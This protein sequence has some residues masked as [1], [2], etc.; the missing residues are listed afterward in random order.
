MPRIDQNAIK[1]VG[2]A[3]ASALLAS[4]SAA[5]SK[6]IST[7]V[8]V[9]LIVLSQYLVC[10]LLLLPWLARRSLKQLSSRRWKTHLARGVAGWLCFYGYYI[11][12]SRVP[13]VDA[14][15]LRNAAPIFVPLVAWL[16][17]GA[18]VPLIRW[19]PLLL[20]LVGTALILQPDSS[21]LGSGHLFGL[22]SGVALAASM[23]GT[24]LLSHTESPGQILFYYTAISLVCS[25]PVGIYQ[26]QPPP[27]WALPYL[28][29]NGL[30]VLLTMW[31]YTRAYAY[32]RPSTIS[33][34]SYFGVVIAGLMG[35]LFWDHIPNPA[36]LTG[37]LIVIAAGGL[38]L[39]LSRGPA[40]TE[41]PDARRHN[42]D[43]QHGSSN[44]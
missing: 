44:Q 31:L 32:A 38:S 1:G 42:H 16:W 6:W 15:L 39:Y 4:S 28:L 21:P 43:I 26:W 3:L 22:L 33:P 27:L 41:A 35:W 5:L 29:I 24:R 2:F 13:L 9:P 30:A 23:V 10:L 25:L 37:M 20:G 17:A 14:A 36:A 19:S 12:L 11:A 34:I 8:P 40:Q 18:R 7:A